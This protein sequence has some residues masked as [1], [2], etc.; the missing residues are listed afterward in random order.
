MGYRCSKEEAVEQIKESAKYVEDKAEMLVGEF[1]RM[2]G[3]TITIRFS[4]DEVPTISVEK[5]YITAG[6][7]EE[8]E[9]CQQ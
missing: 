5:D 4:A 6:Y 9:S 8:V 1:H 7:K 3:L 2:R